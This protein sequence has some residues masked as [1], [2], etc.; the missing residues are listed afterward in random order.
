[1]NGALFED[2]ARTI[3]ATF[4]RTPPQAD[5]Q[6][7]LFR[8]VR[9]IP[10]EACAYLTARICDLDRLP[11]NLGRELRNAWADWRAAHP[12]RAA[13]RDCP[14]CRNAGVRHVWGP[15]ETGWRHFAVPCP[16]CAPGAGP[17][18]ER[19]APDH[20]GGDAD[21]ASFSASAA[22]GTAPFSASPETSLRALERLGCRVMPPDYPG[23]PVAFDRDNGFGRFW[24]LGLDAARP[25]RTLRVG[26]DMR[27]DP[28]RADPCPDEIL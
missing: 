24:P 19:R 10:D 23:G 25:R 8:Q 7:V 6:S 14:D 1:M 3:Y 16:A 28:R 26:V 20:R 2:M 17:E 15:T 21:R 5:I 22:D 12:R 18:A 4:G 13:R 27:P 11:Q 9:H